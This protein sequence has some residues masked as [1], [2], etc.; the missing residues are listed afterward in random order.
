MVEKEDIK[1]DFSFLRAREDILAIL[2]FGSCVKRGGN[3]RS[4]IDICIVAPFC[5]DR[6]G[7]L[8]EVYRNLDVYGKKYDVR[9]FEDLPLYIKIRVMESNEVIYEKDPYELHEYFYFI[10][11]LWEDQAKR[12]ELTRAEIAE[13]F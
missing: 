13:M 10:Q 3:E 9:I 8:R 12:Q 11:R 5:K 6:I 4:D 2:L 7:L 1:R